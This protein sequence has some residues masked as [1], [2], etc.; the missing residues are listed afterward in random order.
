MNSPIPATVVSSDTIQV[1]GES[2]NASTFKRHGSADE[3]VMSGPR[4]FIPPE[5]P[6]RTLV[7]SFQISDS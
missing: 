2:P 1:I 6:F 5:H 7:Q 3:Q 4:T